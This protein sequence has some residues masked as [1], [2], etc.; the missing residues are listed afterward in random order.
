LAPD[1]AAQEEQ[2]SLN[3]LDDVVYLIHAK[4]SLPEKI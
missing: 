1:Q 2:G 3:P 4:I